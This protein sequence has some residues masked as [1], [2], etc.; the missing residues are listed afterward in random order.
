[1][2]IEMS[3]FMFYYLNFVTVLLLLF[4]SWFILVRDV[5]TFEALCRRDINGTRLIPAGR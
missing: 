2:S 1:M 3:P 5:K 4:V